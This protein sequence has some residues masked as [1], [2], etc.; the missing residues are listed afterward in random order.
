MDGGRWRDG[1]YGGKSRRSSRAFASSTSFLRTLHPTNSTHDGERCWYPTGHDV[2]SQYCT[3]VTLCHVRPTRVSISARHLP[4]TCH[5]PSIPLNEGRASVSND[6][7]SLNDNHIKPAPFVASKVALIFLTSLCRSD[8]VMHT[9][10]HP[11]IRS[12]SPLPQPQQNPFELLFPSSANTNSTASA[13][14]QSSPEQYGLL[15]RRLQEERSITHDVRNSESK[16]YVSRKGHPKLL[17][18]GQRRYARQRSL[19]SLILT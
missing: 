14:T 10:Y 3:A 13:S 12:P 16:S 1:R 6:C 15:T 17:L 11:N 9:L 5:S 7:L 2:S 18:M 4:K 8:P 19:L